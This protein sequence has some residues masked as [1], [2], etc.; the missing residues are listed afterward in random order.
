[1]VSK[2]GY[3]TDQSHGVGEVYNGQT[4]TTPE[5]SH[6]IVIEGRVTETS[7]SIDKTSSF[8]VNT[9]SPRGTSYF[10]DTFSNSDKIF[11]LFNVSFQEG[12]V[13]LATSTGGY[14]SQG[15][16]TSVD[17]SPL[18]ITQWSNF[19]FTDL[20]PS[21]SDLKYQIYYAS[22]TDWYLIPDTDLSEN[23]IGFDA[24]PVDLS[25]LDITEYSSLRLKANFFSNSTNT[26]PVLKNWEISWMNSAATPISSVVFKLEG[27]KPV[28]KDSA[29]NPIY[30][31][32]VNHSSDSGGHINL[33]DIEWD[34]YTFSVDSETG[35]DL[36]DINPSPQPINL[37]P[38]ATQ[39]VDLYLDAENSL[40]ITIQNFETLEPVFGATV[41]LYNVGLD[42][43]V[44]QYTNANGQTYF[45]PL[46]PA[47]YILEVSSP[48]YA[49]FTGQA[50]I[51]GDN[52]KTIKLEQIE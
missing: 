51:S 10:S 35:L 49:N 16:L 42:Y 4:I 41:R 37:G 7:F 23:S 2:S 43:D 15:F 11:Q 8:S 27:E 24:S 26:T 38:D 39:E 25:G 12:E 40:L 50:L 33:S 46:E 52:I 31:Y 34:K 29:E 17:I 48:S 28:G 19:T 44:S 13:R 30:K 14:L 9:L 21:G 6:P 47:T 20:E 22:G 3:S 32:S 18:D 45:I 1:M 5:K 36:I